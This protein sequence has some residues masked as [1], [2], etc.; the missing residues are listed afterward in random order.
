M[1]IGLHISFEGAL[2]KHIWG[3]FLRKKGKG[4]HFQDLSLSAFFNKSYLSNLQNVFVQI[5]NC[6]CMGL[7]I[8]FEGALPKHICGERNENGRECI[9]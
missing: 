6:I 9:F 7:H 4:V 2:P 3:V 8:S 5:V 1:H